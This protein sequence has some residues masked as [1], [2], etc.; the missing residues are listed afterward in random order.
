MVAYFPNVVYHIIDNALCQRIVVQQTPY[1][2]AQWGVV[3]TEKPV[4][5]LLVAFLQLLDKKLFVKTH[6]VLL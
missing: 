4:V 1:I 2:H 5:G 3:L 6:D